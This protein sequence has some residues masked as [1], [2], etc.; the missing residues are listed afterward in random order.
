[1][2]WDTDQCPRARLISATGIRSAKEQEERL[3][4]ASAISVM[5]VYHPRLGDRRVAP[6]C[7]ILSS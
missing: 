7:S 3:S 5:I 1:M 6:M 4:R 2:T